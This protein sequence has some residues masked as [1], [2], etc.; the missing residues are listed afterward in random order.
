MHRASDWRAP[1]WNN[2]GSTLRRKRRW[3]ARA[4]R[5]RSCS[6]RPPIL[7]L[8]R[9]PIARRNRLFFLRAETHVVKGH[10]EDATNDRDIS[11]PLQRTLPEAHGPGHVGILGQAAVQFRI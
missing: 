2:A 10:T 11:Q 5:C 1:A 6:C 7:I 4:L 8:I 9:A 3:F